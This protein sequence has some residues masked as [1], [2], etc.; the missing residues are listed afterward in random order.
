MLLGI[1]NRLNRD[2]GAGSILAEEFR[3]HQ[4]VVVD[5]GQMPENY[6]GVVKRENPDVLV[7][8]DVTGMGLAPGEYRR[9]PLDTLAGSH[10]FNTHASPPG[11]FISYLQ[12]FVKKVYFIGIQPYHISP[13]EGISDVVRSGI[14][15]IKIILQSG[16]I[17]T[18][19]EL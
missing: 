3:D 13:G 6:T 4:W 2:D 14:E 15:D 5:G 9:V 16:N 8:V 11:M 10:L 7:I 1:G 18:I 12:S 17:E 19:P